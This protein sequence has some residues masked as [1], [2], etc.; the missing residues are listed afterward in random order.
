MATASNP[1]RSEHVNRKPTAN[2]HSQDLSAFAT[3]FSNPNANADCAPAIHEG[4][5]AICKKMGC[6]V[7]E[8][9]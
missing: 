2:P 1:M 6:W 4:L 7:R 5:C 9:P 8:F 3:Q